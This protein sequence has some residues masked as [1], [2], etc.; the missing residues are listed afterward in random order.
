[1][2]SVFGSTLESVIYD[3]TSRIHKY[4]EVDPGKHALSTSYVLR[5][6]SDSPLALA[7]GV[8]SSLIYSLPL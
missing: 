1:V 2:P 7:Y 6:F 3:S 8:L 4:N 5:L